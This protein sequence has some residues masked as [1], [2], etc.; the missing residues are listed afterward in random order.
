MI[1]FNSDKKHSSYTLSNDNLTASMTSNSGTLNGVFFNKGYTSGKWYWEIKIDSATS[2]GMGIGIANN[3][4]PLDNGNYVNTNWRIYRNSASMNSSSVINYGTNYSVGDTIGVLLDMDNGTLEFQKNGV[5]QGV[6]STD[7]GTLG[8]V[9]PVVYMYNGTQKVTVNINTM[10]YLYNLP[11]GY[12]QLDS[13]NEFLILSNDN[14]Y[15]IT[16]NKYGT[17]NLILPMTSN[18]TPS[19]QVITTTSSTGSGLLW[20]AFDGTTTNH[21]VANGSTP[22][23]T[24]DLGFKYKVG[25]Y[26]ILSTSNQ[27]PKDWTFEGSNDGSNW[28]VLDKRV[29]ELIYTTNEKREFTFTNPD[30]YSQY[31]INITAN[32]GAIYTRF[33][34]IEFYEQFNGKL[35]VMDNNNNEDKYIKFGMNKGATIDLD[36]QMTNKVFVEQSSTPLGNGKVIKTTID[37]LKTSIKK[38]TIK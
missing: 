7:L 16:E 15:S 9:Y 36:S 13:L 24:I 8:E 32:H 6:A 3:L 38:L 29:N 12:K 23:I 4:A 28:I 5:S 18:D 10:T 25:K 27:S 20:Y 30:E 21:W 14:Y 33:I 31:R 17:Q 37:T 34:E 26:T 11:D 35:L 22:N 19:P 2:I 1:G